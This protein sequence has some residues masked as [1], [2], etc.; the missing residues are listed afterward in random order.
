MDYEVIEGWRGMMV[1]AGLG[2]PVQR[3]LTAAL[4]TGIASYA[5]N[6]PRDA[7]DK[8]GNPYQEFLLMPAAVGTAVA[9]LL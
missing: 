3:G 8:E 7:F 9:L 4:V 6:K 2:G 5:I 1:A